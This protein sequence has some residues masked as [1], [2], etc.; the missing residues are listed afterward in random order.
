MLA[1]TALTFFFGLTHVGG[2]QCVD[3]RC[4]VLQLRL[5][6]VAMP[7]FLAFFGLKAL[8]SLVELVVVAH[9]REATPSNVLRLT[10]LL[11]LV[12]FDR[13]RHPVVDY[14][15]LAGLPLL[16]KRILAVHFLMSFTHHGIELMQRR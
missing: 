4:D 5:P 11:F 6:L 3:L 1:V 7:L 2:W 12:F 13:L 15:V 8:T 9:L 10:V 14:W 16:L